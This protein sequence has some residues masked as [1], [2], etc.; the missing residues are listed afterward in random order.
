MG[1]AYKIIDL[2]LADLAG[3]LHFKQSSLQQQDIWLQQ[4]VA[5]PKQSKLPSLR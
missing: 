4:F 5:V 2:P 3:I 1:N